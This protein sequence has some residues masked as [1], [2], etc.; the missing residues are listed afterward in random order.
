[1]DVVY[2]L[3]G[4]NHYN[5]LEGS[6]TLYPPKL[7]DWLLSFL[8][9]VGGEEGEGLVGLVSMTCANDITGVLCHH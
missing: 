4:K 7:L 3:E 8:K 5:T 9:L 6:I 2:F 1:M